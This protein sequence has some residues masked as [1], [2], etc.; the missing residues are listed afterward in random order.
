[1]PLRE[2]L[3]VQAVEMITDPPPQLNIESV[4]VRVPSDGQ[5]ASLC[6]YGDNDGV[7]IEW[8]FNWLHNFQAQGCCAMKATQRPC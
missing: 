3:K 6:R 8:H 1:M 2:G 7:Q 4:I 5:I